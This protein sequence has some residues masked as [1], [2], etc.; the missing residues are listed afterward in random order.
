ML[1][2]IGVDVA[3]TLLF[4]NLVNGNKDS[5]LLNIA[6]AI[7]D[8]SSKEFHRRAQTHIG[9]DKRRNVIPEL[10]YLTVENPIVLLE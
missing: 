1:L 4:E 3:D 7:V 10:A 5:C 9:I 8:G 2:Y 6:K